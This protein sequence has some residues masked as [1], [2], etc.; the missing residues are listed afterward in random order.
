MPP[1]SGAL[2]SQFSPKNLNL[3]GSTAPHK[4]DLSPVNFSLFPNLNVSFKKRRFESVDEY[5][6]KPIQQRT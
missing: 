1:R 2:C 6:K 3:I 5:Q 4:P